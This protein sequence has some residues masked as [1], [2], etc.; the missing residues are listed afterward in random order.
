VKTRVQVFAKAPVPGKVKTRLMPRLGRRRAAGLQAWLI[1]R[2]LRTALAAQLGPVEL[3]CAPDRS[4]PFFEACARRF[5]VSLADQGEGNLGE[6]MHRAL[7]TATINGRRA[8]LIGCD[9]PA[10]STADLEAAVQALEQGADLTFVPAE[11]GGY[12]LIGAN[13]APASVFEEVAWGTPRV[14]AQT[15]ER[16]LA[17][18]LTWTELAARWDV[19]RPED[20]ER[21]QRE[22]YWQA[23]EAGA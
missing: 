15:R 6:R 7:A 5:A 14:M 16:M 1:E 3:W 17:A 4:H 9:C 23:D 2:T 19:D 13:R 22:G 10:L 8:L 20:F 11:D 12:V 21:L 18:G